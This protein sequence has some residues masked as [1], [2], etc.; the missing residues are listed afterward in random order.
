MAV[1]WSGWLSQTSPIPRSPDGDKNC[2]TS[3]IYTCTGGLI[4]F[5]IV[6]W[7]VLSQL[8]WPLLFCSTVG[9]VAAPVSVSEAKIQITLLR[10]VGDPVWKSKKKRQMRQKRQLGF[11]NI[12]LDDLTVQWSTRINNGKVGK[13]KT[14][15]LSIQNMA[16]KILKKLRNTDSPDPLLRIIS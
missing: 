4:R 16:T 12:P 6:I 2:Y 7:S 11:P 1:G 13:F 8:K 9:G 5:Y 3:E 14:V 10:L 15:Y